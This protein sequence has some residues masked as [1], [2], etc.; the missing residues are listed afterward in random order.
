VIKALDHTEIPGVDGIG[1]L[2]AMWNPNRARTFFTYGGFWK[3]NPESP[4]GLSVNP[5]FGR[6][7][8]Q[9][10]HNGS[11]NI[12][13]QPDDWIFLR[14]NQSE[15]VFLQFGDIAVYDKGEI[16]DSWPILGQS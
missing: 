2:M 5:L 3:A 16:V 11:E 13:L 6:S 4:A 15:F 9:E 7:T 1:T 14:P 12:T 8:N 10:M